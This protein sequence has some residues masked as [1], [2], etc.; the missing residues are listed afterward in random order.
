M[1][2]N[3]ALAVLLTTATPLQA[4]SNV[5]ND[6]LGA[7]P[8]C[9]QIY[10]VNQAP[11][12]FG[13]EQEI[14]ASLNCVPAEINSTWYRFSPQRSG[15][16]GFLLTPDNPDSD[17][18]W[19]LFDI[20][21]L[22]C[23][24]IR[25]NRDMLVSCNA[26][27]NS[28]CQGPTGATGATGFLIQ[29]QNCGENPP[30]I[31]EGF[32]PF[33][34]RIDVVVGRTYVLMINVFSGDGGYELDFGVSDDIGIFDEIPPDLATVDFSQAC[35]G[36]FLT[37]EFTE[38]IQCLSLASDNF[39]L[40]GP[41]G[42]YS[43]TLGSVNCN[44]GLEFSRNFV[45]EVNPPID[46][47]GSFTLD[48]QVDGVSEAL[49]RCGNP[50]AANSFTFAGVE[51]T[52]FLEL[53]PDTSL[54]EG[55]SLVLDAG[56]AAGAYRW[57][58]GSSEATLNVTAAGV[59]AVTVVNVC[60]EITDQVEINFL[61]TA[62]PDINLGADFALC[63][64]DS[65]TLDATTAGATY[66]WQ[67]GS[68]DPVY[69][70]R[71][72]GI[73]A[74]TVTTACG[75]V[76]EEVMA[77]VAGTIDANLDDREIC[78]GESFTWDVSTM[79]ATYLWQD[80]SAAPTLNVSSPGD[81]SVTITTNCETVELNAVVS[82]SASA[83]PRVDLG[84]DTVLC[85]GQ[86]LVFDLSDVTN[87]EFI[88]GD[89][90]TGAVFVITSPGDY[91]VVATNECGETTDEISILPSEAISATLDGASI[92]AGESVSWDV[93]TP[94]A[95]YLWQDGSTEAVYT[96]SAPG[97]YAVTITTDCDTAML[98]AEVSSF[99]EALPAIDLGEDADLCAD[100]E[101]RLSVDVTAGAAV[102]WQDGSNETD[103][104]VSQPGTYTVSVS[105]VCGMVTD[106]I[107]IGQVP[108]IE[109]NIPEDTVL[110]RG[111]NVLLNATS[112]HATTYLWDNGTT[113]PEF[114]VQ[115]PGIYEVVI[116]NSCEEMVVAV[117]V[118][119]C[120][121]C[122]F[123]V[124]DAFSPNG[125][126]VNDTFRPF[127]NCSIESFNLKVF[128]RWGGLVFETTNPDFGWDGRAA[129]S[130][131]LGQGVYIW[132]IDMSAGDGERFSAYRL[133]GSVAVVK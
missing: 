116:A 97:D 6:C 82:T 80:Q 56:T 57:S 128:D 58:D 33:N 70:V 38:D 114:L 103:L 23:S 54:C 66:L 49:D 60:G 34:D 47:P 19:S 102:E 3:L 46:D 64:G 87:T 71:E 123:A 74:V 25:N 31:L 55:S 84:P 50:A 129:D 8:V 83:L 112:T 30:N 92:C 17:Y 73:Y 4:Q 86:N 22:P 42:P 65:V 104:L 113:Q 133:Q 120:Q 106:D 107:V 105:N 79:G 68:T 21:D 122:A 13:S 10:Q 108:P 95:T 52:G 88:W 118:D 15:K 69:R 63:P 7:I 39:A 117:R 100:E 35:N 101:I 2:R 85:P 119:A 14:S 76:E 24:E 12:G 109:Y 16:F 27:G 96:A 99:A 44:A 81:Y 28:G 90:S 75:E 93:T 32:S 110:C 126:G 9:R 41:G 127:S 125:D 131:V 124:P 1:I 5:N 51:D 26:S 48:L 132:V 40:G 115:S 121:E 91:S 43:L 62:P 37:V 18:D 53:G 77:S 45:L 36:R 72:E 130:G 20:T 111:E 98:S 59:Y 67:D 94:G 29:G 61:P 78:P 89:G 11:V